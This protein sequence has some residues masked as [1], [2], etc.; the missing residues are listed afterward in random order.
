MLFHTCVLMS[1]DKAEILY[2]RKYDI[3]SVLCEHNIGIGRYNKI[4]NENTNNVL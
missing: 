4:F 1:T 2:D 3:I